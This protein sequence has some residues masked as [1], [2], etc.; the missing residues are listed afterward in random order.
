MRLQRRLTYALTS[1]TF[2]RCGFCKGRKSENRSMK[3][4][5]ATFA[6]VC[7]FAVN[8][9][10]QTEFHWGFKGGI[11][12]T[13]YD[14]D[15][16][17]V[18]ARMGQWG[19]VGRWKFNDNFALQTELFYARMGVRSLEKPLYWFGEHDSYY[20]NEDLL[21]KKFRLQLLTDNVQL[22]VIFKWYLPVN[23]FGGRGLNIHAG[24]LASIRFDYKISTSSPQGY[25]LD[26]KL[27]GEGSTD[28]NVNNSLRNIAHAQNK[29]T[30]HAV[31]GIGYDSPSGIGVDIR[32]QMGITPV[33]DS[34]HRYCYNSHSHDRVWAICFSYTF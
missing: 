27:G 20:Q 11:N 21:N 16:D 4:L 33:F 34:D 18:Q 19:L 29:F 31:Y 15:V 25:L 17:D 3:K 13:T 5:L 30:M 9:A 23:I 32:C 28:P 2:L 8:S 1:G 7:M 12:F 26:P 14:S 24:P 22:P 10:A 6:L